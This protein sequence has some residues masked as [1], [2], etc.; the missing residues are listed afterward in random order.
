[1]QEYPGP[2]EGIPFLMQ[3]TLCIWE[4]VDALKHVLAVLVVMC[5][6]SLPQSGYVCPLLERVERE[7]NW[8]VS[9]SQ[10]LRAY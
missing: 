10:W 3:D 8:E 7:Q 5:T 4:S 2:E 9:C 6:C 1:M